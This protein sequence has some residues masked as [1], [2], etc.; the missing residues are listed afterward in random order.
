MEQ[1]NRDKWLGILEIISVRKPDEAEAEWAELMAELG[2]SSRHFVAVYE[3]IRESKWREAEN[4]LAY[5]KTVARRA[6]AVEKRRRERLGLGRDA[7]QTVGPEFDEDDEK[8]GPEE[9]L[10]RLEHQSS[11]KAAR[12][13]NGV[14]RSAAGPEAAQDFELLK[15]QRKPRRAPDTKGLASFVRRAKQIEAEL[16]A[17]G[18]YVEPEP[19]PE[20]W[21]DW[22]QWAA[23]A[24]LSEWEKKV[25][26]Y[27]MSRIGPEQ[28]L[29]EQ[30]DEESRLALQ[31]AW[32]KFERTALERLRA[33]APV[34]EDEV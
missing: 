21:P 10:D 13:A 15:P 1:A 30:P 4:P 2:L 16:R 6:G 3:A 7:E 32:R 14:W 26:F 29:R 31:A 11:G 33:A 9:T 34:D 19:E 22:Q 25:A 27:K 17:Q 18:R 5:I 28:A 20:I 8:S 12:G 23:N 24:G